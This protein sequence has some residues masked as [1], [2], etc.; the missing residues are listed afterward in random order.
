MNKS[1][2][3]GRRPGKPDTRDAILAVAQRRFMTDGY[4]AVTLR[5]VAAEAGVDVALINYFFGP[6]RGLF[7]AVMALSTNPADVLRQSLQGDPFSLPQ[8]ALAN[9]LAIWEDEAAG[10][11][12]RLLMRSAISDPSM[13]PLVREMLE[14]E[15]LGVVAEALGGRDARK[16]AAAFTAAMAGVLIARYVIEVEPVKSMPADEL[17]RMYAPV[18]AAA[19]R[20][21]PT[22]A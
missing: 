14:V 20:I 3:R 13:T 16:R 22:R 19:L 1:R 5:A 8:R 4:Q 7:A 10:S 11:G 6:K 17:V 9:A 21:R 15:M 18:L 2:S 12:L